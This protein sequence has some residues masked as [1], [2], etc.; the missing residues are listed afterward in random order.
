N[1]SDPLYLSSLIHVYISRRNVRAALRPPLSIPPFRTITH[2][3]QAF[4]RSCSLVSNSLPP[5]VTSATSVFTFRSRL[6]KHL[7]NP[8]YPK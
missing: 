7:L 3:D 1:S 4:S 8:S 6:K 5:S 2:G